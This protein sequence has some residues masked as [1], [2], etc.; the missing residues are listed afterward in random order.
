MGGLVKKNIILKDQELVL[1]TA[2]CLFIQEIDSLVLSDLHVGKSAHFQKFGIPISKDILLNDLSRLSDLIQFFQPSKV[3]VVGDLFHAEYNKDL[4]T[5]KT[6]LLQFSEIEFVLIKGNHDRLKNQI[7]EDLNIVYYELKATFG[8][9]DFVHDTE[10]YSLNEDQ[11]TISGHLHPGVLLKGKGRQRV[12]LPCYIQT[13]DEIILPAF[14]EF[15]GLNAKINKEKATYFGFTK[16]KI[17][18]IK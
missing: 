18:E 12:K 13:K 3:I 16:D 14:S 6:W 17:L 7:Y 8:Q 4:D 5:F 15:T 2:R 9:F 10:N 1:T 11:I